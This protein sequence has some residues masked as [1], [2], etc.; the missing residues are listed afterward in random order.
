MEDDVAINRLLNAHVD[1]AMDSL[2]SSPG[3]TELDSPYR[4][5]GQPTLSDISG[6]KYTIQA[7]QVFIG[8]K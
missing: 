6:E 5:A 3:F 1:P 8:S 4:P 7:G 2:R